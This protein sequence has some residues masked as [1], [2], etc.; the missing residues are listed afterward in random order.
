MFVAGDI[1]KDKEGE[2]NFSSSKERNSIFQEKPEPSPLSS[3]LYYGG[4]EDMY[5][6]SSSPHAPEAESDVSF[7]M[8]M[9][10]YLVIK[11]AYQSF[12]C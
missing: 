11:I 4:K 2:S 1:T 10:L 12:A 5:V 8:P 3:S 7:L 9:N 6:R